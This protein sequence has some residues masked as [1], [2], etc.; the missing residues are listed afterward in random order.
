MIQSRDTSNTESMSASDRLEQPEASR[1]ATGM[2]KTTKGRTFHQGNNHGCQFVAD[3]QLISDVAAVQYQVVWGELE[4]PDTP[5]GTM[6]GKRCDY[7]RVKK[8]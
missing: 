2:G 6:T 5:F 1:S 7:V 4:Q 8:Q 3:G